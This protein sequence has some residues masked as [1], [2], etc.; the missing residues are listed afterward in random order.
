M[1]GR[2][3]VE[4]AR[5]PCARGSCSGRIQLLRPFFGLNE[6]GSSRDRFAGEPDRRPEL[7]LRLTVGVMGDKDRL[8]DDGRAADRRCF[9][10]R[11]LLGCEGVEEGAKARASDESPLD[12]VDGMG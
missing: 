8:D 4:S 9:D 7:R 6:P 1:P 5:K 10:E 2:R 3:R 11:R 12:A